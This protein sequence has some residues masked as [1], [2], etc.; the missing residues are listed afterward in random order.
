MVT[1]FDPNI[2]ESS[3]SPL[4]FFT[5]EVQ[6]AGFGAFASGSV[7]AV[8]KD[9]ECGKVVLGRGGQSLTD[10]SVTSLLGTSDKMIFLLLFCSS[11]E[12]TLK[13]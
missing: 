6:C 13:D 5:C 7:A 10:E 8:W 2:N 1:C 9:V 3:E 12:F 4:N 11:A